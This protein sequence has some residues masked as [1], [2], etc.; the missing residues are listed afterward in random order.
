VAPANG[1]IVYS[2]LLFLTRSFVSSDS[3]AIE[4][5]RP[6]TTSKTRAALRTLPRRQDAAVKAIA[7]DW[8]AGDSG[9]VNTAQALAKAGA[10]PNDLRLKALALQ[11]QQ[12]VARHVS[13]L[14]AAMGA[15]R[16]QQLDSFVRVSSTVKGGAA[17]QVAK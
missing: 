5:H 10:A 17:A 9:I 3:E 11:R 6:V 15:A 16:F 8:R 12:L 1:V 13:Q 2:P 4:L 7:A 14:R